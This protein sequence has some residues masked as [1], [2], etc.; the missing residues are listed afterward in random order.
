MTMTSDRPDAK[1]VAGHHSGDD[2]V[3]AQAGAPG[4]HEDPRLSGSEPVSGPRPISVLLYSDDMDTRAKVRMAIGKRLAVDLPPVEWT[5]C[6][7]PPAVIS[8]V[9][10][11]GFDV[12]VLD[13][14]AVPAGGMGLC[15]Q[16]KE[17]IF[18][19]PPIVVLTGRP[20][21]AWL[22]TWSRADAAVAHP[23]D[24]RALAEAITVLARRRRG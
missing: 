7:T 15:R 16:L 9:D 10:A 14:E 6:A 22:A 20:Q 17:E 8:A 24:P 5:E 21:D 11:G 23:L 19:C 13:G 4:D 12:L 2:L 3:P 1:A 18:E